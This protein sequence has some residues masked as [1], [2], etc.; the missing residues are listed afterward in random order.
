MCS[1]LEKNMGLCSCRTRWRVKTRIKKGWE[2]RPR[3]SR[4][5]NFINRRF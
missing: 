3:E 5:T 4:P 1:G 2:R